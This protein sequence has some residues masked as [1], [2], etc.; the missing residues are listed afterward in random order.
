MKIAHIAVSALSVHQKRVETAANNIVNHMTTGTDKTVFRPG[1]TLSITR[2]NG[3][4][5]ART[6]LLSPGT[7]PFV[8]PDHPQADANG[9]V[10]APR[11]SLISE[12]VE[13][14]T[15]SI[16]YKASLKLLQTADEMAADLLE[17][18]NNQDNR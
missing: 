3:G 9:L 6:S 5:M 4:V 16:S 11:L 17:A 1:R 7:V 15:A 13:M 18:D 8:S 2:E 10:Q 14:K 12:M